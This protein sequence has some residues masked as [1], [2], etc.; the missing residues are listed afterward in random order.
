MIRESGRR[1]IVPCGKCNFCLETK[2]ADWT[3]R[4]L[5]EMR[6]A[7]SA[8]FLTIT[9]AEQGTDK[10]DANGEIVGKF[11]GPPLSGSGQPQ[12]CKIDV[13]NFTKRLRKEQAQVSKETLRYY[14]CAEYGTKTERPHYHS[15][16]FNLSFGVVPNIPFIWGKGHVHVGTVTPASIHYVTKYCINKEVPYPGREP[17]FALM[18]RRP[19]I[20][21]NYIETHKQWHVQGK[22]NYV[23]VNGIKGRIPRYYKDQ[24]FSK[25]MRERLAAESIELGDI[26]YS[27][28]VSEISR[29][30]DDPYYYFDERV[31]ND[32]E[33]IASKVNQH[34]TF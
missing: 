27:E 15:I 21:S 11:D 16:M 3:F 12:V 24:L 13:Q 7:S 9:Y 28:E 6:R 25:P 14:T 5:Q 20:G 4:L 1:D 32:H 29:F 33:S 23:Q 18:S 34:N 19:G 31:R 17:P 10:P 30:H 8:H 2:R 26:A 22:R